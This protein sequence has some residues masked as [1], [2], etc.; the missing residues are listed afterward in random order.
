MDQVQVGDKIEGYLGGVFGDSYGVKTCIATGFY[1]DTRWALFH[2]DGHRGPSFTA[3]I[4]DDLNGLKE[5]SEMEAHWRAAEEAG[6]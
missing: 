2:E 6:E 1:A 4:G 3:L 5:A